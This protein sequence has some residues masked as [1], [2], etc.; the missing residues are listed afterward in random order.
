MG[1]GQRDGAA[2]QDVEEAAKNGGTV[3][4]AGPQRRA[5]GTVP[6]GGRIWN[7]T[8][9]TV[10]RHAGAYSWEIKVGANAAAQVGFH[11]TPPTAQRPDGN[12]AAVTCVSNAIGRCRG[13]VPAV[14]I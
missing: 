4:F 3:H 13:S 10:T 2:E 11:G 5:T 9:G 1:D 14:A 7:V 6:T 8:D 12:R